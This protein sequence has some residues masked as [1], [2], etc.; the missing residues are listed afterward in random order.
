MTV[1]TLIRVCSVKPSTGETCYFT[2][3]PSEVP[4]CALPGALSPISSLQECKV[5]ECP[6]LR[7]FL[8]FAIQEPLTHPNDVGWLYTVDCYSLGSWG[9]AV[10]DFLRTVGCTILAVEVFKVNGS[11]CLQAKH[12][13]P[14]G[15]SWLLLQQHHKVTA[16]NKQTE[17]HCENTI[18][19]TGAFAPTG[20]AAP[21][22]QTYIGKN[23][24]ILLFDFY[25]LVMLSC[26]RYSRD[27]LECQTV[28]WGFFP[29]KAH[30]IK[31]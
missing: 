12:S 17:N 8:A 13:G 25:T 15:G 4:K 10:K 1:K 7:S 18:Y 14:G 5:S 27:S 31:M 21:R 9:E 3:C 26:L 30:L 20:W 16:N 11:F 2:V 24:T 6:C 19:R 23:G 22:W 28:F 29:F